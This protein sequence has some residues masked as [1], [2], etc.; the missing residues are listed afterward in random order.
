MN[1]KLIE[2]MTVYDIN[3]QCNETSL[4]SSFVGE[5]VAMIIIILLN[6]TLFFF[7]SVLSARAYEAHSARNLYPPDI[8]FKN[9]KNSNPFLAREFSVSS[10]C[11]SNYYRGLLVTGWYSAS[12]DANK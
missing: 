1:G 10:S 12:D 4:E 5:S 11:F 2:C 3:I 8:I 9:M 7:F 6:V